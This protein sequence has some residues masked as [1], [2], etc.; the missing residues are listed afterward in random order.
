MADSATLT[1]PETSKQAT[2]SVDDLASQFNAP[3]YQGGDAGDN[4]QS[5]A[6]VR[7]RA[8]LQETKED[9]LADPLN[10]ASSALPSSSGPSGYVGQGGQQNLGP[11]IPQPQ[12]NAQP[13]QGNQQEQERNNQNNQSAQNPL[14]VTRKNSDKLNNPKS[15]LK[16][17]RNKTRNEKQNKRKK[18]KRAE[19]IKNYPHPISLT[20]FMVIGSLAVATDITSLVLLITGVGEIIGWLLGVLFAIIYWIFIYRP[21]PKDPFFRSKI[22]IRAVI[23]FFV[24]WL[25]FLGSVWVGNTLVVIYAYVLIMAYE[26]GRLTPP[27]NKATSAVAAGKLPR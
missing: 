19:I 15:G 27:P 16:G 5:L 14:A 11:S 18:Q 22:N 23:N 7:N 8:R 25:P 21:S 6:G 24:E 26:S 12:G 17:D 4:Q 3:S 1:P 2:P 9:A 13:Q 20:T 10:P